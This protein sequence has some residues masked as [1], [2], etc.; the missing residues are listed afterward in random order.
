M[1]GRAYHCAPCGAELWAQW[2]E[3]NGYRCRRC[4]GFTPNAALGLPETGPAP[5]S[6]PLDGTWV[7]PGYRSGHLRATIACITLGLASGSVFVIAILTFGVIGLLG[8]AD[9]GSLAIGGAGGYVEVVAAWSLVNGVTVIL[10]AVAFLAWQSRSVA[11]VPWLGGGTPGISPGWS[12]GWWL[13]PFANMF[14]PYRS[15]ADLERRTTFGAPRSR[16]LGAWWVLFVACNVA[17]GLLSF[18]MTD[19]TSIDDARALVVVDVIALLGLATSGVLGIAV[20]R[21][22]QRASEARAAALGLP[23]GVPVGGP[24]WGAQ[25]QVDGDGEAAAAGSAPAA[26]PE[27]DGASSPTAARSVPVRPDLLACPSCGRRRAS[28]FRYCVACRFDFT[29]AG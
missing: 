1:T 29:R 4:G 23:D 20:V 9:P 22:V 12:I 18:A 8:D 16:L 15:M 7:S 24:A 10:A 3:G 17:D 19:T 6:T 11:N 28:A 2:R 27:T 21:G 26:E 25:P 13:V 14:M 5:R